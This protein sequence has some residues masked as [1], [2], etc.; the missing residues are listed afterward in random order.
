LRQADLKKFFGIFGLNQKTVKKAAP[1][2][3]E[4][5]PV[6]VKARQLVARCAKISARMPL[7]YRHAVGA[8][9][10]GSGIELC[11][12][13]RRAYRETRNLERKIALAGKI[14]EVCDE[15]LIILAVAQDN[16]VIARLDYTESVDDCVSI[17]RQT[18]GWLRS[19]RGENK[20]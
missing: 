20:A 19:L 14:E 4:N 18:S 6:Y 7:N 17:V 2:P 15:V 3:V 16:G 1:R 12:A 5:T 13:I 8:Q 9:L 11:K 10:F